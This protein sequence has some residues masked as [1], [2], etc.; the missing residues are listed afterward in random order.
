[1]AEV[2][3]LLG[4]YG[5]HPS[6]AR[7][8]RGLLDAADLRRQQSNPTAIEMAP[9][10][11]L[12]CDPVELAVGLKLRIARKIARRQLLSFEEAMALFLARGRLRAPVTRTRLEFLELA[13]QRFAKAY[14]GGIAVRASPADISLGRY[15]A[16]SSGLE[17]ELIPGRERLADPV[18]ASNLDAFAKLMDQITDELAPYQRFVARNPERAA[19]VG[20]SLLLPPELGTPRFEA[21]AGELR[22]WLA[23]RP[24]A[25]GTAEVSF[26]ELLPAVLGVGPAALDTKRHAMLAQA[27]QRLGMGIEPDPAFTGTRAKPDDKAF[28]F[29]VA[30][31]DR[32]RETIRPAYR[33]AAALASLVAGIAVA[34]G[35]RLG[36]AEDRW[37][38]W[39]DELLGLAED[40]QRR[41]RAHVTWLASR[42]LGL[43]QFRR[44]VSEIPAAERHRIARFAAEVAAADGHLAT[45]EVGFLEK[46]Y[47][48]L[49]VHRTDLYSDLHTIMGDRALPA[50]EPVDLVLPGEP[51]PGHALP[52]APR[53][54]TAVGH[55]DPTKVAEITRQTEQVAALLGG[56]FVEESGPALAETPVASMKTPHG[57]GAFLGLDAAHAALLHRLAVRDA[58]NR[59]ELVAMAGEL[60]LMPDGTVETINEWAFERFDEAV[61]ED[62]ACISIARTLLGETAPI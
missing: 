55:L 51:V 56:I 14:P 18:W 25:G 38:G 13:R 24:S 47:E 4:V 59:E 46:A 37:L 29:D 35:G 16:A 33:R 32:L 53:P 9:L 28:L 30:S 39:V 5:R 62:G 7:Y 42:G 36:D 61:I 21:A 8:G 34:N 22:R 40:E 54:V 15:M 2:E 57:N 26:R 6:F 27:L 41:L 19:T 52:P 44:L 20:A 60:G 1:M 45:A 11:D 49:G 31:P 17:V 10:P 3:R 48:E 50:D 43:A 12:G 58:W 23:D